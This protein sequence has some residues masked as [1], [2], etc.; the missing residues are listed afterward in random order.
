MQKHLLQ[1]ISLTLVNEI[2][3]DNVRTFDPPNARLQI[4]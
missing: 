1:L 4:H 2:A 3:A